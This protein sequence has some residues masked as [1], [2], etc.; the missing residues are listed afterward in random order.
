[1]R[2]PKNTVRQYVINDL[3]NPFKQH[4][5]RVYKDHHVY[6]NQAINGVLFYSSFE[7][8]RRG[9]GYHEYLAANR[10]VG[11]H[12]AV[13]EYREERERKHRIGVGTTASG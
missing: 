11:R 1:L 3:H 2:F 7:R 12:V 8:T 4:V 10:K 9:D 5:F 13:A 6:Y